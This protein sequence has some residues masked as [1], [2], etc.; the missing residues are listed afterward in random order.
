[1]KKLCSLILS[2][3]ANA[4][5]STNIYCIFDYTFYLKSLEQGSVSHVLNNIN[6]KV[7]RIMDLVTSLKL[8]SISQDFGNFKPFWS[9]ITV[10][11]PIMAFV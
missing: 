1:M 3:L 6:D 10:L 11:W 4:N 8:C 9:Y 2:F 5:L 7:F